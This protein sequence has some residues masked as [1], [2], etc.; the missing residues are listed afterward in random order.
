VAALHHLY[1]G[2][3]WPLD[4]VLKGK[5]EVEAVGLSWSVVESI[6]I[7]FH[8]AQVDAAPVVHWALEG[9]HGIG[10]ESG[11]QDSLLHL[12]ADG[13]LDPY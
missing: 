10:G 2:E 8:Q 11:S 9:F 3:V 6:P 13:G 4:E 1:R 12:H 7:H 5:A